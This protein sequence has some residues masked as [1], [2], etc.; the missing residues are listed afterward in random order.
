MAPCVVIRPLVV[1]SN[2]RK[3]DLERLLDQV[4]SHPD[5]RP[6]LEQYRTPSGIAGQLLLLA[7]K[8]GAIEG[9][10]VLDLGSGTG[11]FAIGAAALG[12]RLATGVEV[13]PAAVALAQQAAARAGFTDKCWFIAARLEDWHADP[14]TF[15]AVLMNPPFGAQK[16]NKH[17]DRLFLE[18]A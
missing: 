14:G 18:R 9:K 10:N 6:E 1:H 5:P 2:V 12:A 7:A 11:L 16:D 4:P 13:D 8:D 3:A 17:A 15:D